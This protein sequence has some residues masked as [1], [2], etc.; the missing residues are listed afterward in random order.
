MKKIADTVIEL[1]I[2]TRR[3][4]MC[5][6]QAGKKKST[7]SLKTKVLYLVYN[8]CPAREIM[9]TLCIAKTNFAQIVAALIKDGLIVKSRAYDDRRTMRLTVTGK[10]RKYLSDCKNVTES[11][12]KKAFSDEESYSE[13]QRKLAEALEVFS[14][15]DI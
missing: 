12:F 9:L 8:N 15:I 4:C 10:G 2:A 6:T 3:A 1:R 5:E 13:A 7:L 11:Y 14:Y